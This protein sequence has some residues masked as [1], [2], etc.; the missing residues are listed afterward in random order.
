MTMTIDPSRGTGRTYRMIMGLPRSGS[1][2]VAPTEVLAR[3]LRM[4]VLD[5]RGAAVAD[6]TVFTGLAREKAVAAR[7]HL[8]V[9]R[10]HSCELP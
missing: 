10:D 3:C 9:Y 1:V 4:Q 6:A 7:N 8:P 2:V 5:L